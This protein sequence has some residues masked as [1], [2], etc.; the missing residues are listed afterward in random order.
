ME[1]LL[2]NGILFN[3]ESPLRGETFVTKKIVKALTKIKFEKQKCLYLGNLYAKRDLG[4]AKDYVIAMWKILQ[5]V[6]KA[7]IS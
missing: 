4:H 1:F 2:Q 3:H 5:V 6:K 7:M